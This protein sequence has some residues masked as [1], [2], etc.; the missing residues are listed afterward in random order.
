[1][2]RRVVPATSR[3]LVSA[4]AL[5]AVSVL[6][7]CG[8]DE[9]GAGTAPLVRV[10]EDAGT[11]SEAVAR[12]APG[13]T[14]L[15]G[16]GLYLESVVVDVPDVTVRGTD[17][18]GVVLD[19]ELSRSDGI[20]VTADGV[21][22]ENLTVRRFAVNGVLVTRVVTAGAEG[23]E[24][25]ATTPEEGF[26][27]RFEVSHVTAANNGLYGI[28]ALH[29]RHGTIRDSYASGSADAGIYVGQCTRCD[30]LVA[31]NVAERNAVGF[32][33]ANA[34]GVVVVGNRLVGN[35][36][37]ATMTSTYLEQFP[38]QRDNVVVGNLVAANDRVDAPE[39]AEGGFGIGI[40]IGGG[41]GNTV[42]RNRIAGNPGA[43]L[44]VQHSEDFAA[45]GN[46]IAGNRF[47]GNGVDVAD[48]SAA[49]APS[50]GNCFEANELTTAV[51]ADLVERA[52]CGG[53][54]AVVGG[55][56][57]ELAPSVPGTPFPDV[58]PGPPQPDAPA[59]EAPAARLP[60]QV[61]MPDLAAVVVPPLDLLADRAA[62]AVG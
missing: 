53:A 59:R 46:R 58:P 37:G 29:A 12:V 31:G 52:P 15:V 56:V 38:P 24:E 32:E 17:R 7:A 19:G 34:S 47:D 1:V 6:P 33:D 60:D 11:I 61:P 26:L 4:L 25:G 35:R 18:D 40:G 22:I 28:Y 51:P 16:P 13:G 43:G 49:R 50:S 21:R 41:V 48:L 39:Q 42:E 23:Y 62:V 44:V 36:V 2:P 27:E 5:A 14:V 45:S 10:P 9:P 55:V 3:A 8:D 57:Q 30:V 20:H 54:P